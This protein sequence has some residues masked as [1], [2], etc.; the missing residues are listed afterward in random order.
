MYLYYILNRKTPVY[1]PRFYIERP[2]RGPPGA[3]PRKNALGFLAGPSLRHGFGFL[4]YT[5]RCARPGTNSARAHS[6]SGTHSPHSGLAGLHRRPSPQTF[7][8]VRQCRFPR[9]AWGKPPMWL[10]KAR[11]GSLARQAVHKETTGGGAPSPKQNPSE[12]RAY[13]VRVAA[14]QWN[15]YPEEAETR[16]SARGENGKRAYGVRDAVFAW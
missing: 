16:T 2:S 3:P 10:R 8:P 13:G 4:K 12:P 7:M 11:R 6:A 5:R 1:L 14:S 9:S 15:H